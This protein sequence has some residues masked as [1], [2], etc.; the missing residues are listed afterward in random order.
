[1]ESALESVGL[2]PAVGFLHTDRPGRASLALDM[3]EE[4]RAFLADRMVLSL[5]NRRQVSPKDFVH[6][7]SGGVILKDEAR[8]KVISAWQ[9]RK[10]D[11]LVHPY[12]DEKIEIGLI[13]YTQALLLSRY[14][15]GDINGYPPFFSR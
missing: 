10:Q 4:L 9:K 1:M 7:E 15:R 13:P 6:S 14:I 2:D 3:I 8:K 12:F 11:F 5:V